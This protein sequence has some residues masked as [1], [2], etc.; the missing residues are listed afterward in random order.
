[1]ALKEIED[2]ISK[3]EDK[4]K[5]IKKLE[6]RLQEKESKGLKE[7]KAAI[8]RHEFKE[9]F[10]ELKKEVKKLKSKCKCQK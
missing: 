7:L 9:K 1:M 8:F 6:K 5:Y 4:E 2:L 3:F 10:D